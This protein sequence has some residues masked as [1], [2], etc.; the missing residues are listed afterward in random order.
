VRI[1]AD[2]P[3]T[4]ILQAGDDPTDDVRH[5]M[6][7]YLELQHAGIPA[8]CHLYPHGGRAFSLRAASTAP[9]NWPSLAYT[10]LNE[11]GVL[12][13]SANVPTEWVSSGSI[14]PGMELMTPSRALRPEAD[15]QRLNN[16]EP[17][18]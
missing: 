5:S 9:A 2:C 13:D 16:A 7:Y 12:S 1:A 3:S 6:T 18:F 8:K 10:W 17:G 15:V 4:F 14:L 11:I